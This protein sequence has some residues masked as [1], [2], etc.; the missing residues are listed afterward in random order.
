MSIGPHLL[1]RVL[2]RDEKSRDFEH[3]VRKVTKPQDVIHPFSMPHLDQGNLG[4]CEGNTA[5]E[6]LGTDA[7]V[8]NRRAYW[9]HVG[10]HGDPTRFLTEP[11]A[12]D[13]YSLATTKDN[14]EIPGTYPPDDTGTSGLGIAKALK[15]MGGLVKY[16]WTFTWDAFL[17]TLQQRPVMLGTNWYKSMFEHDAKGYVH[18]SGSQP[19]GGH[20]YLAF[21]VSFTNQ[22][23]GCTNHWTNDDGSIWGVQIGEH[24]GNFWISFKDLERLLINEQGDSLVPVLL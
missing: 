21:A 24:E 9:R 15:A 19:D 13:L 5:A 20:A 11:N 10:G 8:N 23:V 1:G 3:S 6:F 18:V 2:E 12:V 17:G 14:K 7:A 4:S 22:A 16:N